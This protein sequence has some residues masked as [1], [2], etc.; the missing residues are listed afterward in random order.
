MVN[1]EKQMMLLLKL[2]EMEFVQV[3]LHLYLDT[4]PCDQDALNDYNCALQTLE[5]LK[6]EYTDEFGSL[7]QDG[8][9]GAKEW[10]W[11]NSPW[12]WEM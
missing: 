11:I 1:C 3:E 12:P 7:S 5:R 8:F 2:Q 4:H 6:K 9:H 10:N